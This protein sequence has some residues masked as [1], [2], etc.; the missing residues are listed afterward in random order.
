MAVLLTPASI[1]LL[2]V[3]DQIN[4][5]KYQKHRDDV[6]NR[7]QVSAIAGWRA[8]L[9]SERFACYTVTCYYTAAYISRSAVVEQ[10]WALCCITNVLCWE[11]ECSV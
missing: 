6:Q 1:S 5:K 11:Y 3:F 9:A 8:L 4:I 7:V 10:I 2:K